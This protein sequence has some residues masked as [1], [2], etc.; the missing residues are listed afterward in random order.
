MP[1]ARW[2]IVQMARGL[3]RAEQ[4]CA[5]LRKEGILVKAKAVYKNLP[6]AENYFEVHVLESEAEQ[7]REILLENGL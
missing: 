2:M 5:A 1:N 6:D 3:E 7:A 4:V